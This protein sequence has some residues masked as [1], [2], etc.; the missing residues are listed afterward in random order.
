MTR[1]CCLVAV[2][3]A[4]DLCQAQEITLTDAR[5]DIAEA[6]ETLEKVVNFCSRCDATGSIRGQECPACLG[7]PVT[8]KAEGKLNRHKRQLQERAEQAGVPS[9]RYAEFDLAHRLPKYEEELEPQTIQMLEAYVG[10]LKA[11]RKHAELV[12]TDESLQEDTTKTIE[13]LDELID[14]HGSQVTL[15]SFKM[16]YEDDPVGKV[17][18]FKLYGKTGEVRVNGQDA[19]R[20]QMRTLKDWAILV[21]KAEARRRRGYIV[22]EIVGKQTYKTED[23]QSIKAIMLRPW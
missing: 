22:A 11:C 9:A 7:Q 15:R 17:G 12:K 16:L 21:V 1:W 13:Q 3:L 19:E 6:R 2:L 20:Y 5:K 23:G 10:Y 14:R 18:A 4:G 8:L